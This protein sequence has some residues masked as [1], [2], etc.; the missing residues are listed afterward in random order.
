[1]TLSKYIIFK[2]FANFDFH[3]FS[4]TSVFLLH[5][6]HHVHLS[7]LILQNQYLVQQTVPQISYQ[8]N[9]NKPS[10]NMAQYLPRSS[11]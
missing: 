4:T 8:K 11:T 3:T 1:M 9:R 2:W 6:H 5:F 10:L 7:Y